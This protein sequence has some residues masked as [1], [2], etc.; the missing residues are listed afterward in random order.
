MTFFFFF[1]SNL[2][3]VFLHWKY[4]A[5]NS[6]A[7]LMLFDALM[8]T[9]PTQLL[10]I[11]SRQKQGFSSNCC[12]LQKALCWTLSGGQWRPYILRS[13]LSLCHG[14]LWMSSRLGCG[15]VHMGGVWGRGRKQ[16]VCALSLLTH[17]CAA[18]MTAFY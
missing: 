8:V 18:Q 11:V 6:T 1:Y 16:V 14:G 12:T 15:S 5:F 17:I 4:F 7:G 10:S 9:P 2:T 3:F 13:A